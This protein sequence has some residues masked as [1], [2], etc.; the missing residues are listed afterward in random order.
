M[1]YTDIEFDTTKKF[2]FEILPAK[3][4][5]SKNLETIHRF[6][7]FDRDFELCIEQTRIVMV[8]RVFLSEYIY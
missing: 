5:I 4:V 3:I 8:N 1:L 7:K 6:S 2:F